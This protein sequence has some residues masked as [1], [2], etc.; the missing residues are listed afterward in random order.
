LIPNIGATP[1]HYTFRLT[2]LGKKTKTTDWMKLT[3]ATKTTTPAKTTTPTK[4][5]TGSSYCIAPK[6][7]C[8]ADFPAVDD[9]GATSLLVGYVDTNVVC[10]D[11]GVCD[12]PAGDQLDAIVIG[13]TTGPAGMSNPG[14][15][16][17]NFSLNLNGGGQ[18]RI[19]SITCDSSVEHALCGLGPE[20]PTSGFTAAIWFDVPIGSTWSSVD[21]SYI[22]GTSKV[23]VFR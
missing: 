15:E 4:P 16:E 2:F 21:F 7:N 1:K 12:Q 18:G 17:S 11:P 3:E 13:F 22:S 5:T 20:G 23:Y 6:M 14:V 19:D 10:P 9:F 8:W